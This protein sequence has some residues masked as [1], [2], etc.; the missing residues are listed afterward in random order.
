MSAFKEVIYYSLFLFII[1]FWLWDCG[2]GPGILEN[3]AHQSLG[4]LAWMPVKVPCM[5][6]TF[7]FVGV[8]F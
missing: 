5:E 2:A 1:P 6:H 3:H 4:K 7:N 8:F